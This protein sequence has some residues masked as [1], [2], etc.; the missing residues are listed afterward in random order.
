MGSDLVAF[1]RAR[2][3]EDEAAAG[4][5]TPGPWRW[6][7]WGSTFGAPEEER[8]TLEHSPYGEFPAIRQ[9]EIEA[10][11]VLPSG[12]A[13]PIHAD[14]RYLRNGEH[15]VRHDP[16]RVLREV[17]AK[18]AILAEYEPVAKNDGYNG[19][20]EPEYA[21]GWAEGL[22]VAVRALAAVYRDHPDYDPQWAP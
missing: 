12:G 14:E 15:V 8:N 19:G 10:I 17:E 4:A 2:L 20:G 5:A 13:V 21:F 9:R 11:E 3:D 22:G 1:L 16:A 18:R 7:D 6:G